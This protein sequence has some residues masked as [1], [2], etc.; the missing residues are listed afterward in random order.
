MAKI[1]AIVGSP[2]SGKTT[3]TMKLSQEVYCGTDSGAVVFVSSSLKIPALGYLFPNYTADSIYSL[4]DM[5]DKTDIFEDDVLSHLIT[6]KTMKNYGC[7]GYKLGENKYSYASLTMDKVKALF[8][9]LDEMAGYV[10]VDCTDEDDDLISQEALN[11]A[12]QVVMV[13]SPDL[14]SIAYLSS[15]EKLLGTKADQ[16]VK[17]LNITEKDLYLPIE[18]VKSQVK[19][20][21]MILPYSLQ[22]K[23]QMQDGCLYE[24]NKDRAYRKELLKLV[25]RIK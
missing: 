25:N 10:F 1:I 4:G 22:V 20:I 6:V 18:E 8:D 13:I 7:L 2:N 9:V 12:S 5:F 14:K 17:V 11:R 16:I 3:V 23:R 21:E 19:K 24:L 15:N